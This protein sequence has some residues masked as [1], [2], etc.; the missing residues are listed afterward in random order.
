MRPD[1]LLK[2]LREVAATNLGLQLI[3]QH[4]STESEIEDVNVLLDGS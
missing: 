2:S 4:A 1:S 3:V